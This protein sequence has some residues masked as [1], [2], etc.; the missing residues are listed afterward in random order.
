M[1]AA[2]FVACVT[3]IYFG[4]STKDIMLIVLVVGVVFFVI[5]L[6]IRM[7]AE[8]YL[9][10]ST[11]EETLLDAGDSSENDNGDDKEAKDEN[12]LGNSK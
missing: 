7:L 8:K 2:A 10:V 1:L 9:V 12:G 5:G 4:Y 3:T 6:F 11:M